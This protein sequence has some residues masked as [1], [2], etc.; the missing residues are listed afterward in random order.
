MT[1]SH[2]FG[3]LLRCYCFVTTTLRHN[4]LFRRPPR[5]TPVL[6]GFLGS[7][8][9]AISPAPQMKESD[10]LGGRR[11]GWLSADRTPRESSQ[12]LKPHSLET[13]YT[14]L[15]ITRS[16]LLPQSKE[17]CAT[18]F[19]GQGVAHSF[20]CY[21]GNKTNL[22]VSNHVCTQCYSDRLISVQILK[23][24]YFWL[25]GMYA[26]GSK[27]PTHEDLS[28]GQRNGNDGRIKIEDRIEREIDWLE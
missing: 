14:Q 26:W 20:N 9:D 18:A 19:L 5:V 2:C 28:Y 6:S 7:D 17:S 25:L 15:S 12:V 16:P 21:S 3:V 27:P 11:V 23:T 24:R 1:V 8:S 13:V 10:V 4:I 22:I